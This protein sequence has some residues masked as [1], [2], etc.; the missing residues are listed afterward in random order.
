MAAI[1]RRTACLII[2]IDNH[3][4]AYLARLL[5]ARGAAVAGT[6]DPGITAQLGV[7][8]A[9]AAVDDTDIAAAIGEARLVFAISDGSTQR[10]DLLA[11][12][13]EA[14]GG[15][16]QPPRFVHVAE[17]ADVDV[18]TVRDTIA[19][20]TAASGIAAANLLLNA[21]ESRFGTRPTLMAEI[22]AVAARGAAP[23]RV[24]AE[25]GPRDWGWT[26][27]YVDAVQRAALMNKLTDCVI[28]SGHTL[29]ATEITEAAFGYFNRNAAD[30]LRIEGSGTQ[31]APID[32]TAL[33][34]ETGWTATTWGTDLVHALCEGAAA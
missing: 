11:R 2:G 19:R 9:I 16:A 1:P 12:S 6:G 14:A 5:D 4:G 34:A 25:P 17:A 13:L 30:H 8:D 3:V 15:Q 28:A 24:I 31:A 10:A 33:R 29:T 27:E 18:P 7:A 26:P 20:V 32:L 21:H 23:L 22:I